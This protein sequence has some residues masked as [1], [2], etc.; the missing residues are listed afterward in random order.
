MY[1]GNAMTT[2]ELL[3][4]NAGELFSESGFEAVSTR[5]IAEKAGVKLSA[6]HYH[7]GS[8]E[9][10]YLEAFD[11]AKARGQSVKIRDVMN[12]NPSLLKTPAGQA[13]IVKNTVFRRFYHYFREDRA[14]WETQ[15]LVREITNPSSV[16]PVISEKMFDDDADGSIEFYKI[17][18]PEASPKEALAW[19]DLLLG[20]TVFYIMAKDAIKVVRGKGHL[21]ADFYQNAARTLS[22]A[23]ILSLDLPLPDDLK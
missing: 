19:G 21:D 18:K 11:Q 22:R 9:K 14:R 12:E 1:Q 13:E 10:L 2:K 4:V 7:F 23:M 17:V 3:I 8:K 5:A 16:L 20:Q 6:I 15:L